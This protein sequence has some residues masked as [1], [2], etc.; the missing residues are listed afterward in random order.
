MSQ[1]S[2]HHDPK[3][4]ALAKI[5]IFKH[6]TRDELELLAS[7][8]TSVSLE[9]D[10]VLCRQGSLGREFFVIA[11]GEVAVEADGNQA[12]VLGPGSFFGEHS[13]LEHSPRN[14]TVTTITP[15]SAFVFGIGEFSTMLHDAPHATADML[16]EA[17]H[18]ASGK[19]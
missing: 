15:V 18:R 8:S 1:R 13:L 9:A 11:E 3:I 16:I 17:S 2:R 5:G 10:T 4:E 19:I 14:A 12:A 6:C 7:A